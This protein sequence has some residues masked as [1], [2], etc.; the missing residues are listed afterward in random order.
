MKTV[1]PRSPSARWG[2]AGGAVLLAGLW[3]AM[4]VG[5]TGPLDLVILR[6]LYVGNHP[7]LADIARF[8]TQFGDP[9]KLIFASIICALVL[10]VRGH[11]RS[12]ATLLA[13]TLLGRVV[14]QVQKI[15][16]SRVRPD[17]DPHLVDVTSKSFPSGHASSS[18]IFYLALALV[19][20]HRSAWR[21]W[22]AGAAIAFSVMIGTSRV[23]L[24][25]H[26]PSD[27]I[28]GWVFGL[29]W[30]LLTLRIA[31]HLFQANSAAGSNTL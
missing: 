5:G 17:F 23:M 6:S 21:W 24:G 8:V 25:V 22:A 28:G 1:E 9:S 12:A 7:V 29:L 27:V 11:V 2:I 19:L 18:M 30:V 14:S 3:L 13:V 20:T 16:I 31:E 10:V 15:E 4:L 26:W